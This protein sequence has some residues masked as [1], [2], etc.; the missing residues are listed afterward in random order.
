[1]RRFRVRR[2]INLAEHNAASPM[3]PESG[4][5]VWVKAIHLPLATAF[6]E[7][8]GIDLGGGVSFIGP[9]LA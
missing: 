6:S 9:R 5:P 3:R 4:I 2:E 8:Q 1:M 7:L